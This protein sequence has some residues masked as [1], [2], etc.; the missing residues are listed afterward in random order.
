MR[1]DL[2]YGKHRDKR[3]TLKDEVVR[4]YW[5]KKTPQSNVKILDE[6]IRGLRRQVQRHGR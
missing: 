6:R 5:E 1:R 2:S 3:A 4:L